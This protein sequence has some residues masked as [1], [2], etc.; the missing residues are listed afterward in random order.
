METMQI[1]I[2]TTEGMLGTSP[3][4][5]QLYEDHIKSKHPDKKGQDELE[6]LPDIEEEIQKGLTVFHRGKDGGPIVYDYWI[7]GF[8]KDTI[9]ALQDADSDTSP[10]ST[11]AEQKKL[12]LTRW[13][14]KR[15]VDNQ[16]FV[17]PREIKLQLPEGEEL[18]WCERPLRA[19]TQKGER[20]CLAKSEEAPAGTVL[21]FEIKILNKNLKSIVK[22]CLDFGM[23]KGL[24][25]W[26][27]SG[28]GRFNWE[29]IKKA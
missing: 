10:I 7:K 19:E 3:A 17:C 12:G 2:T 25:Q 9:L 21:E 29:E 13:T 16:I 1:K 5:P 22:E 14:Y 6:S 24:G 11:K 20:V 26:R 18:G 27:N 8:F 23:L 15:T 28:K 4:N